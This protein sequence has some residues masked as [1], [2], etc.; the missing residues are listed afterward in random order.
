MC[1]QKTIYILLCARPQIESQ[2]NGIVVLNVQDKIKKKSGFSNLRYTLLSLDV[3][4]MSCE[5]Q[6]YFL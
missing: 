3:N 2:K 1:L 6:M 4:V 5:L